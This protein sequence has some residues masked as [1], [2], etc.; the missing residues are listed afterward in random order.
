LTCSFVPQVIALV[1]ILTTRPI[2]FLRCS[3]NKGLTPR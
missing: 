3:P 2:R 1:D